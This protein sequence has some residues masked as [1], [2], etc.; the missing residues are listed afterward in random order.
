M[1]LD[2]TGSR[3]YIPVTPGLGFRS[4]GTQK[5][6][7]TSRV[8]SLACLLFSVWGW[9]SVSTWESR[10]GSREWRR[11]LMQLAHPSSE[12]PKPERL[13][14]SKDVL[15][16]GAQSVVYSNV[17]KLKAPEIGTIWPLSILDVGYSTCAENCSDLPHLLL[18]LLHS[19]GLPSEA[20][21]W[22][23]FFWQLLWG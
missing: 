10:S 17:S 15:I 11:S 5:W 23:T 20:R 19:S 12:N 14:N 18:I 4:Q 1:V 6:V 8:L 3:N 9:G 2:E 21:P 16:E 13:W 7:G 22:S